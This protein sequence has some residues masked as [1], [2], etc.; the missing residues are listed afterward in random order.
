MSLQFT[1]LSDDEVEIDSPDEDENEENDIVTSNEL[2]TKKPNKLKKEVKKTKLFSFEFDTGEIQRHRINENDNSSDEEEEINEEINNVP[3]DNVRI[4]P[5]SEERAE[6]AAIKAQKKLNSNPTTDTINELEQKAEASYFDSV[7]DTTLEPN[8]IANKI[9]LFSE[10]NLSRPLLRA[11]QSIGY[12]SPTPIQSKVI[13]MAMS[14]RDICASAITGSGKTAAFLL[15]ILER[16]IYRPK[17]N[18]AIHVLV[19]TPTRELAT[20]I[21]SV[22]EKL[23]Q[24]TDI[25]YCLISGG[26]KDV[27]SQEVT[28]R[29][30]PDIVI[31][32]PGR[33]LD[34]LRNSQSI[35]I[36]ELDVLVL[37]EVDRLLDM[38]FQVEVEELIKHCPQNRQTLLFSATMTPKIEDL[39]KLSLRKPIRIKTADST[40]SFAPRL[41]QEFVKVRNEEEVEAM[42]C[43]L[44]CR[45]FKKKTIL[46]YEM[47]KDAHRFSMILTLMNIKVAELHGD[48][49]QTQRY[50]S[51]ERFRRGDADVLV[52]TDVAA[53]GLDIPGVQ[54]VINAEMPRNAS[55]YVHR[56]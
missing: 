41:I 12:V 15:P 32:T 10:L 29:N 26:K 31:C 40:T 53:R 9:L 7:I 23:S 14:G 27:K 33:M 43:A 56:V 28:L 16:L 3:I 2:Q 20:Q 21:Y 38:G 39:I 45:S 54:T 50:E 8:N 52:A 49:H 5:Y 13:P 11:I 34:H 36:D 24:Y 25:T 55:T 37:D 47:K 48:L 51:L 46:F 44:I 42:L 19:I 6:R 30:R 1:I 18:S 4:M 35:T 22:L 17:D